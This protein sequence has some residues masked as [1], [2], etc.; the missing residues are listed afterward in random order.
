[1]RSFQHIQRDINN[2]TNA[3]EIFGKVYDRNVLKKLWPYIS[4]Y[5]LL[6]FCSVI[7][8]LAYT[9]AQVSIPLIIKHAI[10]VYVETKNIQGLQTTFYLFL[11][12]AAIIAVSSYAQQNLIAK[13]GQKILYDLRFDT[14]NHLQKLSM[15][16]YNKTETGRIMSRIMGDV[17]QLQEFLNIVI[18]AATDIFVLAGIIFAMTLLSPKLAMLAMLA[19]PILILSLVVWQPIAIKTYISARRTVSGVNSNLNQNLTGIRAVQSMNRQKINM[20]IFDKL[21]LENQSSNNKSAAISAVIGPIIEVLSAISAGL[22]LFFGSQMITSNAIEIGTLVAMILYIE[23]FYGPIRQITQHYTM[24]QRS[25]ASGG[26]IVELLETPIE[27]QDSPSSPNLPILQGKLEIKNLNYSYPNSEQ[28]L[29]NINLSI[30]PGQ[31]VALVGETGSGKTTLISLITRLYEIEEGNGQILI[32]GFH[33]NQITKKSL[34]DQT[35]IVLQDPFL[36]SGT[37]REN[38][39]Y[40]RPEMPDEEM[41]TAT[42]A[43][44]AHQFI[45]ELENGYDTFMNE[46]GEN[47]SI[48]QRQLISFAR[49]IAHNP[50][51]LILDEATSSID[52]K[53]ENLIQSALETL[54]KGRTAIVIA[55]RLSTIRNSDKI[56]VLKN[57][58]IAEQGTHDELIN[59][60]GIYADLSKIHSTNSKTS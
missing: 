5:K 53:F 32:D 52:S 40:H 44:N 26:R 60:K 24:L 16:F 56:V 9:F 30:K 42:K 41:M 51:L 3:D 25:M 38:I 2:K 21:N 6:V 36:F 49:A 8:M 35:S 15:H 46:R 12:A 33:I 13:A 14:F 22:I 20:N 10:D 4:R 19:T 48:G 57:G 27:K 55:H 58:K 7:A 43:I 31:T 23:R 29:T 54:L 17:F 47:L 11:L 39:K 59:R 18:S 1:M 28:V 37:I 34:L 45:S 50:R